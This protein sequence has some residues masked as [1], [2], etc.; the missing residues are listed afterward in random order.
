[1]P[2]NLHAA[3]NN[4]NTTL[5]TTAETACVTLPSFTPDNPQGQGI[6]VSGDINISPGTGTTSL[7]LKLRQG[8]NTV[9][10]TQV[11]NSITVAS[12]V[13]AVGFNWLDTSA[14]ALNDP[15]GMQYTVTVTQTGATG[16]GTVSAATVTAQSATAVE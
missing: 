16:N 8:A 12:S 2:A 14:L 11:G 10:G 5:V 1:M 9:T 4:G 15:A 13:S 7:V 6:V 3:V